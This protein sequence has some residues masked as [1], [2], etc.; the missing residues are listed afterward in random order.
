MSRGGDC[1]QPRFFLLPLHFCPRIVL[2]LVAG[3]NA[4][5]GDARTGDARPGVCCVSISCLFCLRLF[6]LVSVK[7]SR[8][9]EEW[10]YFRRRRSV[11]R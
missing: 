8:T 6:L 1:V 7:S 2:T 3:G 10:A 5:G 4:R 9:A 11:H